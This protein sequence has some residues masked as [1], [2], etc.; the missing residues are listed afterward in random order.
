MVPDLLVYREM[1][2]SALRERV[3]DR[4]RPG[5]TALDPAYLEA[6]RAQFEEFV[7]AWDRSAVVRVPAGA[8]VLD[9]GVGDQIARQVQDALAGTPHTH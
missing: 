5:E 9:P 1:D 7:G 8:D 2:R 6:V 3:A 4:G